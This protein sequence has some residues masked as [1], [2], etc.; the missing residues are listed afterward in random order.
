M[1]AVNLTQVLEGGRPRVSL[2]GVKEPSP[3]EPAAGPL[4]DRDRAILDFEREAWKLAPPKE[5]AIREHLGI[6]TARYHQL[7]NRA[8]DKPGALEYDPMLVRRLRRR[9]AAARRRRL[10]G[11]FGVQP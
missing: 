1:C 8:I 2:R 3:R 11:R 10:A 9:R 4:D 7:L 6:S 5:R